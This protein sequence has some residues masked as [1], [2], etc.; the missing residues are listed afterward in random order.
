M[1]NL[2]DT[3]RHIGHLSED[4]S[5][6]SSFEGRKD[7]KSAEEVHESKERIKKWEEEERTFR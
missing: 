7:E 1:R 3:R 4:I 6:A 2:I 5:L